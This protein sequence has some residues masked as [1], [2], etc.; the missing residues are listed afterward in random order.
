MLQQVK[1]KLEAADVACVVVTI[2]TFEDIPKFR[3]DNHYTGE[4]YVDS[5][6]LTPTCYAMM[7]L[8]NGKHLLFQ[9]KAD[10][11]NGNNVEA[12]QLLSNVAEAGARA[13]ANGFVDG[14]Y[15]TSDSPYTGDVFQVGG[16]FVVGPGNCCDY[17][18]RSSYVGEQP[19]MTIFLEAAIGRRKRQPTKKSSNGKHISN[20]DDHSG[21]IHEAGEM[22]TEMEGGGDVEVEYPSTRDW[23]K[24]LNSDKRAA[25]PPPGSTQMLYLH[26][27]MLLQR[28]GFRDSNL[29]DVITDI[30]TSL[31][32]CIVMASSASILHEITQNFSIVPKL[33]SVRNF[34][35]LGSP[36]LTFIVGFSLVLYAWIGLQSKLHWSGVPAVRVHGTTELLQ[37]KSNSSRRRS[38]GGSIGSQPNS[39]AGCSAEGSNAAATATTTTV[40]RRRTANNTN[41]S[42]N[43]STS[44]ANDNTNYSSS[45]GSCPARVRGESILDDAAAA[46]VATLGSTIHH[47]HATAIATSAATASSPIELLSFRTIDRLVLSDKR[48]LECDCGFLQG[49][50][51]TSKFDLQRLTESLRSSP[52]PRAAVEVDAEA[53]EAAA[54]DGSSAVLKDST[55][56]TIPGITRLDALQNTQCYVRNFLAKPNKLLGRKGP[57]C[58]FVPKSLKLDSIYLAQISRDQASTTHEIET[59]VKAMIKTFLSIEPTTGPQAPFKAIILVFP[60]IKDYEASEYIDEVQRRLKP[61]FVKEGLMLGEFHKH[62][63]ASGLRNPSFYPLRTPTPC[64]AIRHMVPSDIVFLNSIQYSAQQRMEMIQRYIDKFT[65]TAS[66]AAGTSTT[67]AAAAPADESKELTAAKEAIEAIKQ[68]IARQKK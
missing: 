30:G 18:F 29:F 42:T 16:V 11:E 28:L 32:G 65:S 48:L 51:V 47:H 44:T 41:H 63:N 7:K 49:I 37:Q 2:G 21:T 4:V 6:L 52:L 34:V 50:N 57:T 19:D 23:Q 5:N 20:N 8:G 12:P 64:L 45:S 3:A 15:G 14:G 40:S 67:R 26:L 1:E 66:A 27:R 17:S 54:A 60:D 46:T 24:K 56:V 22:E 13:T 55:V 35:T 9:S 25:A 10:T 58:P 61:H 39:A 53:T 68:E 43:H 62:N 31:T 59:V 38:S 36:I 33:D